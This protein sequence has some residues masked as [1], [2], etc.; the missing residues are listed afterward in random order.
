MIRFKR[1]ALEKRLE[2]RRS[3]FTPHTYLHLQKV[4]DRGAEG[5]D[6]NTL[7]RLCGDLDCLPTDIVEY[8]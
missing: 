6:P 8:V 4:I 1:K 2:E 7:S 5:I 3:H